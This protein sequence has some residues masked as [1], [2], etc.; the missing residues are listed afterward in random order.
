MHASAVN[1]VDL[2]LSAAAIVLKCSA[3]VI[4][5][6]AVVQE[7]VIASPDSFNSAAEAQRALVPSASYCLQ[8]GFLLQ[9]ADGRAFPQK[10]KTNRHGNLLFLDELETSSEEFVE[11]CAHC[12]SHCC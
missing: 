4:F 9:I 8:F 2:R 10:S 7:H 12:E 6:A 5:A 1:Q 3:P 11:V